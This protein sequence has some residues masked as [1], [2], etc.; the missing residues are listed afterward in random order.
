MATDLRL[1]SH[2]RASRRIL[3]FSGA[4]VS[5]ASGIP[6]FRG[7]GGVWTRRQPVYYDD[8]LA[9]E[10]ARVEYWDYKLETW[11]IYQRAKPNALHEAVVAL[12]RAGKV[13]AVVTQNVDGLHRRAGTSPELLVELHGTDLIVECQSCRA[14]SEPAA[15]FATFKATGR[16]PRC[17]CGG[18]L[19]SATISFGQPLRAADLDRAA[20]A[21]AAADL[22]VALGSTL[23]VYPA[24]TIPLL[25]AQRGTPYVIVNRGPS[26]HD[27]HPAVTLR[28]EGDVTT[29]FPPA[30]DAA[31]ATGPGR[32]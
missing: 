11:E 20:R 10:A 23:S 4:G 14:A 32:R 31:L 13:V 28:L 3:I 22:V 6:D 8:F 2:L 18:L 15:H 12:E 27:G 7:P 1:V 16:A 17:E 9:S 21:A 24:A 26:D 25:A 19:K 29:V 5:T 30:V